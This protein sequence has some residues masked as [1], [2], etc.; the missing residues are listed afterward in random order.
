[1]SVGHLQWILITSDR[2]EAL[3]STHPS[4]SDVLI[5]TAQTPYMC[6]R[7]DYPRTVLG[8]RSPLLGSLL[9]IAC[10]GVALS[11]KQSWLTVSVVTLFSIMHIDVNKRR[12][13]TFGGNTVTTDC[14]FVEKN[15]L[16]DELYQQGWYD[17]LAELVRWMRYLITY[18]I[19]SIH[20]TVVKPRI[21]ITIP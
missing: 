8:T 3:V 2:E 18:S 5:M 13:A 15:T 11:R 12:I 1:M 14:G 4:A 16:A 20:T 7:N 10:K 21:L 9:L 6:T 17:S 19:D